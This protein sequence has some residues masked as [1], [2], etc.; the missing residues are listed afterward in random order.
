MPRCR[1]SDAL[2]AE[3][4]R[5]IAC[6]EQAEDIAN[7]IGTTVASLRATCSALRISLRN[8]G[9]PPGGRRIDGFKPTAPE[10]MRLSLSVETR[11]RLE[12]EARKR[13]VQAVEL[14]RDVLSIV[15][16]DNIFAAVLDD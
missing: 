13:G 6:G 15:A 3:I 12:I 7:A 10:P 8:G 2:V 14:C 16:A 9:S 11:A 1:Y 4:R 5:R